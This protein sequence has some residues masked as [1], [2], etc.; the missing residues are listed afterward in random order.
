MEII[1]QLL[2]RSSIIINEVCY[3]KVIQKISKVIV[4]W[5]RKLI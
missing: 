3:W 1:T 2:G 5:N 4:K